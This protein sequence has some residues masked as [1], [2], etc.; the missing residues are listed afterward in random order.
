MMS[1]PKQ[2]LR[3]SL[4]EC[5]PPKKDLGIESRVGIFWHWIETWAWTS[6]EFHS[7]AISCQQWG[8]HVFPSMNDVWETDAAT[9]Q[10]IR[11]WDRIHTCSSRPFW[12]PSVWTAY[13]RNLLG[14]PRWGIRGG[15]CA[16]VIAGEPMEEWD[17]EWGCNPIL[18][19]SPLN[20]RKFIWLMQWIWYKF[21]GIQLDS[22]KKHLILGLRNHHSETQRNNN[23]LRCERIKATNIELKFNQQTIYCRGRPELI[24]KNRGLVAF[25]Q[26]K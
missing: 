19:I 13:E 14:L 3:P 8:I 2:K 17:E 5:G 16:V 21:N 18:K 15:C 23:K 1:T 22:T 25:N 11:I 9:V 24:N 12:D 4:G 7:A 6:I 26:R 20:P 10:D